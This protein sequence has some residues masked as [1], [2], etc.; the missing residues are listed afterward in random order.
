MLEAKVR[1]WQAA[2]AQRLKR[3]GEMP[4]KVRKTS[5]E[6]EKGLAEAATW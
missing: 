6:E 2:G 5:A 4:L 1:S 3:G